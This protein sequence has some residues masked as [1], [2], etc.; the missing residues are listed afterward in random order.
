LL[1]ELVLVGPSGDL[2][3]PVSKKI[4]RTVPVMK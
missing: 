1:Q 3:H 2:V 4:H